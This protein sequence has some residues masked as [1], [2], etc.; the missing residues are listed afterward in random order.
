[1]PKVATPLS[2]AKVKTAKPGRYFDGD[3][4]VLLI[5]RPK[6]KPGEPQ[7]PDRAFWLFRYSSGG[8]VREMGLGR[9][10]GHNAV[11]LADARDRARRLR[12][13][14]RDKTDPLDERKAAEAQAKADAAK[15][16]AGAVTFRTA[17]V[18]YVKAHE[19]GWRNER[20]RQQWSGSLRDYVLPTLGDLPVAA[21]D[22]GAV[23]Q[24]IEPLWG[25][26][27]ETASRVRG[28]IESIL[29][30]AA[31]R[32]W[33]DRSA[34]NPAT[35]RGHLDQLLP[36][37]SRVQRVIHYDAV[38][39]RDISSFMEKL[40]ATD[41]MASLALQFA[42]LTAC[43]SNEVLGARRDEIDAKGNVW[44]IPEGTRTKNHNELRIPLSTSAVELLARAAKLGGDNELVFPHDNGRKLAKDAMSR[45][46]NAIDANV[47]VHGTCRATFK[48]WAAETGKPA[49]VTEAALNH[50]MGKLDQSYQRGDLLE[51]RRVL[52]Q[53]WA[54]WCATPRPAD[55]GN[56]VELRGTAA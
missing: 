55:G 4:L 26:K 3:G 30:Y 11:A 49:D 10:R 21:V 39:W 12:D 27:T 31:A 46:L 14:V 8:K 36:K 13:K 16:A 40:K 6:P 35:W 7:Q 20:H 38:P 32:G 17:A 47:T 1:M 44:A 50:A 48:T 15:A 34:L 22:T 43:R 37:R 29:D 51:R 33:R 18:A 2:A 5:R 25:E 41:G 56:V 23:M 24:I 28:R 54:D 9:A 53:A 19:A 52:M 45:V 42:I